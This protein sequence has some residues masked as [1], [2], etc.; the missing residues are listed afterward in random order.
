MVSGVYKAAPGG[1][2]IYTMPPHQHPYEWDI[3][4]IFAESM[5]L[6]LF[7]A[8]KDCT[9]D[10]D[11]FA[12]TF[13]LK[14]GAH[15]GVLTDKQITD[16]FIDEPQKA[17][18]MIALRNCC[19]GGSVNTSRV[20]GLGAPV[21]LSGWTNRWHCGRYN[22]DGTNGS[23][24]PR[25]GPQCLACRKMQ[26]ENPP[27]F[28]YNADTLEVFFGKHSLLQGKGQIYK[29]KKNNA[30]GSVD[31]FMKLS[32]KEVYTDFFTETENAALIEVHRSLHTNTNHHWRSK[33]HWEVSKLKKKH[34]VDIEDRIEKYSELFRTKRD[35]ITELEAR[36]K[37][38]EARVRELQMRENV[39]TQFATRQ[40]RRL[41]KERETIQ[42]LREKIEELETEVEFG[43]KRKREEDVLTVLADL[44]GRR[45]E[46]PFTHVQQALCEAKKL[47]INLEG[48][49]KEMRADTCT[50][51]SFLCPIT[52][53]IMKDPVVV[54]ETGHTYERVAIEKWLVTNNTCP[55]TNLTLTDKKVTPN[56]ILRTLIEEHVARQVV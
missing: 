5:E 33:E 9:S 1:V 20:N 4:T 14:I 17:E 26:L 52:C 11:R 3:A 23:C 28:A 47:V 7:S 8:L 53:A 38:F 13:K 18:H 55:K 42:D 45:M 6:G 27:P 46:G 12:T 50:P 10:L 41:E 35:E 39:S 44:S 36:V 24:G 29:F 15:L 56:H 48:Q 51:E 37:E 43:K 49:V 32:E 30:I 19:R 54:S 25:D 21:T 40:M 22:V 16:H 2:S 34:A 31:E